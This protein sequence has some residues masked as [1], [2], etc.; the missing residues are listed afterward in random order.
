MLVSSLV[1]CLSAGPAFCAAGFKGIRRFGAGAD[2]LAL[3]LMLVCVSLPVRAQISVQ[4]KAAPL[5]DHYGAAAGTY[6]SALDES[7]ALTQAAVDTCNPGS[8]LNGQYATNLVPKTS[9]NNA[10]L[11]NGQWYWNW[12]DLVV[13]VTPQ[14]GSTTCN[15]TSPY[16]A[17]VLS[18]LCPS[19][20]TGTQFKQ[21]GS[22]PLSYSVYCSYNFFVPKDCPSCKA[23]DPIDTADAEETQTETDY[24]AV[25][26]GLTFTRTYRSDRASGFT[27]VVSGS[28]V[29]YSQTYGAQLNGSFSSY[30]T[31]PDGTQH[32]VSLPYIALESQTY[33]LATP[34]GNFVPFSGPN[35]AVTQSADIND[36]VAQISVNGVNEW[37]VTREDGSVEIYSAAG[38]LFQ[39]TLLGGES[40]TYTYSTSSTPSNIAPWP[41]LLIAES[42]P[43]GHTLSWQYNASGQM[44]QMTDP[45]GGVY[46]YSYDGYGNL[47]GVA[48]PD[49]TSRSYVYNEQAY[50]GNNNFP[51]ALTGVI[52]ESSTRYATITYA[53]G[54]S[55]V[56]GAPIAVATQHAGVDTYAVSYPYVTHSAQVTDPLGTQRTYNFTSVKTYIETTSIAQPAASGSG[57]VTDS[58]SYDANDNVSQFVDFNGNVTKHAYDLSRNLE[59]SRT[60]A[61]GTAPVRTT[62]TTWDANWRQPDLISL[63]N[64]GTGTGT[65]IKT[66][67]FTYDSNGNLLTKTIIDTTVTPNISRTWTYTYDSY[68]RMLTAKGP[69]T[70]VN[71]TTTYAYYTCTTGYQ[72]GEIQTV[73]DPVGNVTTY[74]T[75]NAHGQPLTITDP[76]GIVTTLAYDARMRLTSRQVGTET[77]TFSYYPTGL[78]KKVTLPD[79]SYVLYTY[80]AAHRLTQISDGAGNSIQYTLD[81]AG[82]RTAEKTYDPSNNLHRTHTRVFNSLN[83][84]YQDVNAA[85]TSAVTTTYTY[86]N[87]ANQTAV[88]APLSR[89]TGNGFDQLNRI[90]Q[91]TDP[92]SGKTYFGYD[93]ADDL[94]SVKDPRS[95]TTSYTYNGFG[96]VKQL[97]SPDTGTTTSTYDSAGNLATSTDARGAVSTY[98][99]DAANRVTSIAY[100]LSGTT[101]QTIVFGYDSGTNG[102]G[103]LTGASDANHSLAW[104]YDGLGRVVGKGLTVGSANLSVG[105]AYTSADLTAIVTPSG[106]SLTYGYN[107]NHQITSVTVNGTTVLSGVTYEPFGGVNGWTW[108]DNSTMSRTFNGDGLISQIATAGVTLGYSFDNANRITGISDSSNSALSWTYGYDLL[109]RLTS[110]T[111]SAITD[112]WTYDADGNQLTQTGTTPITFI[113]SSTS[114]QL[115]ATT[116]SL[117]RSYS[118]D[119]AGHTTGYGTNGFTYNNRG[120]IAATVASSTDY[121]YNALGQMIEKSGTLGTTLFMQD[122]GGHLIGEYSSSGGLVEETVWLGDIPVATLQP[123]GSGGVNIFYVHTDHLNTP[124]KISQPTT[125]TLAWRYDS[126]PFGTVAPNQNPG[127]LGTFPYNLRFPGQYYQA[128]TGLNQNRFRDYDPEVGRYVESDPI[129]VKAGANTYGYVGGRPVTSRDALGLAVGDFPPPPPGYDPAT[130]PTGRW[131][132]TRR[133][134]VQNPLTRQYFTCHPEDTGHWRHWDDGDGGSW[135]PKSDKP[136]PNQKKPPYADQ[137]ATDPSGNAPPWQPPWQ[138]YWDPWQIQNPGDVPYFPIFGETPIYFTSPNLT[139]APVY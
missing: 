85:N 114:N 135:P 76:N 61:Y 19:E 33:A 64:N 46:Q 45:A 118:Y 116:G 74:N 25:L 41:G 108:G 40:I 134:W 49:G 117:V 88:A 107:S 16:G 94:T 66:T 30:V 70:D 78:L 28:F 52:D 126:D 48:Y 121:L 13:C 120:R 75:Y 43:F 110:A 102:K 103:R 9:G 53:R 86:D 69:R 136:W 124:R 96:D 101:D 81:N 29:D 95:L 125:G 90:S 72:C 35:N 58:W 73:T 27:S 11:Y 84:L 65:P 38:S 87:D 44:T 138:P 22:N 7:W 122:E 5:W 21:I 137:S 113:P 133:W 15:T 119:A 104:T 20:S 17:I 55:P 82:N 139:L 77:T 39:K 123:N 79:S 112:G 50:T 2:T 51:R 71:S 3:S 8:C 106:Q 36:R 127:G 63:Y 131:L 83:Q 93:A 23:A 57:T 12:F 1:R 60:E 111:T 97:V 18:E 100:S 105:Y 34:E 130:W 24:A 6:A 99:Y 91:I 42:D 37:Q 80:D 115:T 129:G 10:Y 4:T 54:T 92:N 109:D 128:E 59:T 14:G 26:P 56:S 47:T 31:W 62:T 132:L 32:S 67:G 98:A 68:G 89:N